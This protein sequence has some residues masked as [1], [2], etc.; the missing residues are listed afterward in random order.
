LLSA[1]RL[2]ESEARLLNAE[3]RLLD[4]TG[5]RTSG[6][7][8]AKPAACQDLQIS[9]A[10]ARAYR[11]MALGDLDGT[12]AHAG[13]AL[14]L[15]SC[16]DSLFRTRAMAM[17]GFAEY[18]SGNLAEAE[19]Q[20]LEF[21]NSMWQVHDLASAIGITFI[22]ADIKL[23]QTSN[24]SRVVCAM[25]SPRMFSLSSW[26][27][28]CMRRRFWARRICTG[29]LESCSA[30]RA[31]LTRQRAIWPWR[32]GWVNR[33]RSPAGP[34]AFTWPV[35]RLYVAR[36]RLRELQGDPAGALTFLEEAERVVVR[37][38][39]PTRSIVALQARMLVRLG[40]WKDALHR[41]HARGLTPHDPPAYVHEFEYLVLARVLT[42]RYGAD[43]VEGERQDIVDLL[44]RLLTAASEGGRTGSVIEILVQQAL[45]LQVCG[46]GL[47]ALEALS[48]AVDLA[49]PEGYQRVFLDEG[50]AM[51]SRIRSLPHSLAGAST[52]A[53]AGFLCLPTPG[54]LRSSGGS[55]P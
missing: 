22:L 10:A 34:S 50:A 8:G 36:A 35:Q 19:H 51:R 14:A 47:G 13:Q 3:R 29:G 37:N 18:A 16:P 45:T 52:R 31:T 17:L 27:T 21:Q 40:R 48:R 26:P 46:D 53:S 23:W 7:L 32:N 5:D 55:A 44:D 11:A 25:R 12:R 4:W 39:L 43:P 1:G 54:G 28:V 6:R 41:M 42:A 2:E 38:P 20:L 30:N 49:E 9:I 24:G 15:S 33:A